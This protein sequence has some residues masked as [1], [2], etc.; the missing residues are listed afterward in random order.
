[1]CNPEINHEIH[2]QL[3]AVIIILIQPEWI[4]KLGEVK[5]T[6]S[7]TGHDDHNKGQKNKK[8]KMERASKD[9]ENNS[10]YTY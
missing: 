7:I 1:M 2:F 8:N 10:T 4:R 5:L 6:T 9:S 3:T